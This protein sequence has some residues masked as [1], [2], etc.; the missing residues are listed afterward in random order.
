[1]SEMKPT[2][3][4]RDASLH[5]F[6]AAIAIATAFFGAMILD[7]RT[8]GL[9]LVAVAGG[10]NIGVIIES[11]RWENREEKPGDSLGTITSPDD[12]AKK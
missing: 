9:V 3:E 1:M 7:P 11:R 6:V 10:L 5:G 12:G 2:F 4:P 8:V